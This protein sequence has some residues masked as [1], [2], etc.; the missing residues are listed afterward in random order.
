[1]QKWSITHKHPLKISVLLFERFSNLCLANCLEPMRAANDFSASPAF[2]WQFF[3]PDGTPVHSSSHL[4]VIPH[5]AARE[6]PPSDYLFILASYD[7]LAHDTPKT[8]RLLRHL[9]SK[10]KILVGL[11][12][13]PWLLASANLL[14]G[15]R[16]TVHWDVIQDFAERFLETDA[17]R[18]R[19]VWD[20]TR[21]TCAGAMSAFDLTRSLIQK[22]LGNAMA[23]DVD[24]LFL[25]DNP[26]APTPRRYDTT[27]PTSVQKAIALMQANLETPLSL[28]D[29][30][31]AIACP[32]KTLSRR[33]HSAMGASP[34]QVY[35][36]LRL[37]H[38]RQLVETTGLNIY[39][40]ALRAGYNSPAAL[41]R[42]YKARFGHA[43]TFTNP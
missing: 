30:S 22:H 42:A 41:T 3:T 28:E 33:F 15:R 10:A 8:R 31:N 39:E 14:E 17:V 36:H 20:D 4:P 1:M 9:A 13:A 32:P 2:Q 5:A 34:G 18:H 37:T 38:A 21:V 24:A 23:L 16:A 7:Y 19:V 26:D 25:R 12:T 29:I 11:D 6:M 27:R 43:P 35:R 40:I